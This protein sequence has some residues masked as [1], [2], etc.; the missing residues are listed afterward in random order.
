[1]YTNRTGRSPALL[2]VVLTL[3]LAFA[4][5]PPTLAQTNDPHLSKQEYL[6]TI[7][8]IDAWN[9]YPEAGTPPKTAI[10]GPGNALP[11]HEDL[12]VGIP[13]YGQQEAFS[14]Q[15]HTS[16]FAGGIMYALTNN[17]TGIAGINS[18]PNFNALGNRFYSS[19]AGSLKDYNDVPNAVY[20]FEIGT[21]ASKTQE[22]LDKG[23][24]ILLTPVIVP[25]DDDQLT[26][27]TN[28]L[29]SPVTSVPGIDIE[30]PTILGDFLEA[31]GGWFLSESQR[32]SKIGDLKAA[33][34]LAAKGG[35][36]SVAANGPVATP[37]DRPATVW[38]A[39]LSDHDIVFSVGGT[40]KEGTSRWSKS[41][42]SASSNPGGGTLDVVAPAENVFSTLNSERPGAPK[43]G[44]ESSTAASAAM[45]AGVASLL[46]D[47]DP[48]LEGDDLR[49][50]LRRTADDIPPQG[51]DEETGYGRL[52]ANAAVDY[53]ASRD[54][55]HGT[56]KNGN[57]T[58][59]EKKTSF[60]MVASPWT[61]LA[62]EKYFADERYKVQWTIDL[63]P[64]EDHD[65]WVRRGDTDGWS[66]GN[67][68]DGMPD[69]NI[70]VRSW[71]SEATITTYGYQGKVT[72]LL[73]RTISTY[74]YPV[75]A[76]DAKVTYTV[77]TKP[78]TPPPPPLNGVTLNGPYR[79]DTGEQGTWYASV[80]P[81]EG[82][83]SYYWEHSPTYSSSWVNSGCTGAS[84]SKSFY[85]SCDQTKTA[86]V[87][88]TVTRGSQTET[89][90]DFVSI[91]PTS[92]GTLTAGDVEPNAP[93]CGFSY[94]STSA[95][96]AARGRLPVNS[97]E[98]AVQED[99]TVRLSWRAAGSALVAPVTVQHRT[100][101]TAAWADLGVVRLADSVGTGTETGPTYQF[102]TDRLDPG[103][104]Q[105]RLAYAAPGP[106]KQSMRATQAV[107]ATVEM[108][109]AYRLATY[110]N[111]VRE[112]TT[113][114]LAVKEQQEVTVQVYDVLGRQVKTLYQSS[115]QAQE[116]KRLSLDA[117]EVGL[118][119]GTYFVR[120]RGESFV[121]TKR[122]TIVR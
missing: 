50:I 10:I 42:L 17:N 105:F 51:Y 81:D 75:R 88:V 108:N 86:K 47:I 122:L 44:R 58:V 33:H 118:S 63:P 98:T 14:A 71:E 23:A 20:A 112:Q 68:T 103:P 84:C 22:A 32:A 93:P 117:S 49:Q 29:A 34:T 101:S 3:S 19:E 80:S 79:L 78:G 90:S 114:E 8:V 83:T 85:N 15:P 31:I 77:A 121:A 39:H 12:N 38:P 43:Y 13:Q 28:L 69:A 82:P 7:N 116:P 76:N 113:V 4:F 55:S 21:A 30:V 48:G 72:D 111:P 56:V 9:G 45:A 24:D 54:I 16:T 27:S 41:A 91:A 37:F 102:Q 70:E 5:V 99:R 89:A 59:V 96:A 40:T 53:V 73:G 120:V 25:E 67:P 115:M 87:R 65:V 52:N 6:E 107:T 35:Q 26:F 119:S 97:L 110:P 1:M 36:F 11:K 74:G 64:G 109:E 92:D 61:D 62:S 100:D 66:P 2:A 104:H 18:S 60:T 106:T 46:K 94:S 95:K 57:V